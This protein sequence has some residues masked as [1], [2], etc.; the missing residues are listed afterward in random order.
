[1]T[2]KSGLAAGLL[3][4]SIATASIASAAEPGK[5][6]PDPTRDPI[7]STAGFLSSHPDLRYRLLGMERMRD[8][9]LNEAFDS[10][11]DGTVIRQVIDFEA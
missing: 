9:K 5:A 11:S 3:L 10:L 6:P 8:G 1:M 4:T 2:V 7:M